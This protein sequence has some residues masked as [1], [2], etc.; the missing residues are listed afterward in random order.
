MNLERGRDSKLEEGIWEMH[1]GTEALGVDVST[2]GE[3]VER[4]KGASGQDFQ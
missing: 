4:E 1:M 3:S 2:K